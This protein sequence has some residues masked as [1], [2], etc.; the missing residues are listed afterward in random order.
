MGDDAAEFAGRV[1]LMAAGTVFDLT[2]AFIFS[3]YGARYFHGI[4]RRV[5]AVIT[6]GT[7]RIPSSLRQVPTGSIPKPRGY[8]WLA[9]YVGIGTFV[10][11]AGGVITTFL[12]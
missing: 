10:A 6:L 4:G 12:V 11:A 1:A 9:L 3:K 7:K 2:S 8:D 5:I